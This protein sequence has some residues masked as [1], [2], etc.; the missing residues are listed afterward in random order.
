MHT[1]NMC[2]RLYFE[3]KNEQKQELCFSYHEAIVWEEY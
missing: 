2:V 3:N 1:H